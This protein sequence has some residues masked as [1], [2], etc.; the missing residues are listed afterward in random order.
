MTILNGALIEEQ[1][2][3][4]A[5]VKYIETL[6]AMKDLLFALEFNLN[7]K[8]EDDEKVFKQLPSMMLQIEYAMQDGWRFS[9]DC[10]R[11]TWGRRFHHCTCYEN[12]SCVLHGSGRV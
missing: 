8:D 10:H 11:H 7:P 1:G 4:N 2:I 5:E 3:S 9:R 6:H 12:G